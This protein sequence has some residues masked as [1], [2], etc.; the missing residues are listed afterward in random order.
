MT[1]FSIIGILLI[2]ALAIYFFISKNKLENEV[3]EKEQIIRTL[4]LYISQLE[5]AATKVS[6]AD[7][8]IVNTNTSSGVS[9]I[10]LTH[11]T[12]KKKDKKK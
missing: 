4:Q 10:A 7:T 9:A 1:L 11:E 8:K 12:P 5:T 2:S 3:D 6:S